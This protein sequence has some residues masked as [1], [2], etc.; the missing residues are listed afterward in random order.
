MT[1]SRLAKQKAKRIEVKHLHEEGRLDG[2]TDGQMGNISHPIRDGVW[3][4]FGAGFECAVQTDK[5][6]YASWTDLGRTF[7]DY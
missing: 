7:H 2:R 5:P 6:A 4:S 1:S 3:C